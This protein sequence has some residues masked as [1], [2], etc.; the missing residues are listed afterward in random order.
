MSRRL[1]ISHADECDLA[2][3]VGALKLWYHVRVDLFGLRG[4]KEAFIS[5]KRE[6]N[7]EY[8]KRANQLIPVLKECNNPILLFF[9]QSALPAEE[10]KVHFLKVPKTTDKLLETLALDTKRLQQ[11]KEI[12]PHW[13]IVIQNPM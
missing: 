5:A 1:V 10:H 11:L 6:N 2:D 3:Q 4:N 8:A 13:N 12:F 9:F 7:E